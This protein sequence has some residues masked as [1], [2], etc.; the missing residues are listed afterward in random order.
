MK[1]NNVL[2]NLFLWMCMATIAVSTFSCTS[3]DENSE[4]TGL[5]SAEVIGTFK[6]YFY[7]S[8]GV[9]ANKLD[10]YQ[11]DEFCVISNTKERPCAFFTELTGIEA[12]LKAQYKYVYKSTDGTCT[13][14]IE[15]TDTPVNGVYAI[16]RV[17]I[18]ECSDIKIIHIGT[19]RLLDGANVGNED[20]LVVP[21]TL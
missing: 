6:K 21:V 12:P 7:N 18:P 4:P 3:D 9:H 2:K 5:P 17:N 14:S 13:I 8:D 10:T 19:M 20:D 15:G 16:L 1:Q 11:V